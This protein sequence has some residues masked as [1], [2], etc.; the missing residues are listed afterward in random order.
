MIPVRSD[1][2]DDGN[3]RSCPYCARTFTTVR[4]RR[5]H[6]AEAHSERLDDSQWAEVADAR[7]AEAADLRRL[8]LK[9]AILLVGLYF[10]FV[11]LYA[12]VSSGGG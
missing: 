4:L 6:F 11:V 1:G 2:R 8:R 7:A 10:G 5:L 12:L 9:M 3:V